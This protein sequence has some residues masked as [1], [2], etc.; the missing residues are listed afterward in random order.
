VL[1]FLPIFEATGFKYGE[2]HSPKGRF[3]HFSQSDEA[4]AFL[5]ALYQNNWIVRFNWSKWSK[6]RSIYQD[7]PTQLD[8]VDLETLRK[9]LYRFTEVRAARRRVRDGRRKPNRT[10]LLL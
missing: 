8:D 7:R 3:P 5:R 1:R 10:V 9:L 4:S 6:G 2:W